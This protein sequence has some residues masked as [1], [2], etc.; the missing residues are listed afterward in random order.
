MGWDRELKEEAARLKNKMLVWGKKQ[1][2]ATAQSRR[3]ENGT[4]GGKG[5][6]G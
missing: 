2:R 4:R 3:K 6:Q 5:Q 1:R